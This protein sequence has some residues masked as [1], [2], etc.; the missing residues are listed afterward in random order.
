MEIRNYKDLPYTALYAGVSASETFVFN[1]F[2]AKV[3]RYEPGAK[4]P[5]H[6]HSG[7]NLK[8]ILQ[9][10]LNFNGEKIGH[11]GTMYPCKPQDGY[12][13]EALEETYVLLVQEPG[14]KTVL[15]E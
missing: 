10:G 7:D 11:A 13:L 15:I 6:N 14:T 9:G 12:W 1:G 5:K 4:A 3:I 2:E 8:V